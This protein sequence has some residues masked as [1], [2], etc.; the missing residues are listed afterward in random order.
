MA[1]RRRLNGSEWSRSRGG[2]VLLVFLVLLFL[3]EG[4]EGREGRESYC[5]V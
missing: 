1:G 5:A 3:G 2:C 4:R